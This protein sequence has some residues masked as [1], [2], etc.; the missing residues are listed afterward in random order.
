MSEAAKTQNCWEFMNCLPSV[1]E[2]CPAYTLN[3]GDE[4][5]KV[6]RNYSSPHCPRL[7]DNFFFCFNCPW[8]K[9]LHP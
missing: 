2:A 5:W 7:R 9:K 4:C 1:R 8:Y 6:A 3:R